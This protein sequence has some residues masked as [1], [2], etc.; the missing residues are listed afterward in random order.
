MALL[1]CWG[2]RPSSAHAAQLR[3]AMQVCT[4]TSTIDAGHCPL[5]LRP[6]RLRQILVAALEQ[7]P[8]YNYGTLRS[9]Y[10]AG[11]LRIEQVTHPSGLPAYLVE[12]DGLEVCVL[13]LI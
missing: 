3:P 8:Q 4:E 13:I 9:A 2:M 6:Q 11:T 12:Y 7:W 10:N 1:A 5:G